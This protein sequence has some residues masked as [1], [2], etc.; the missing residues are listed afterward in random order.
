MTTLVIQ[1]VN[2]HVNKKIVLVCYFFLRLN[3]TF[4]EIKNHTQSTYMHL[5][6][7]TG[8]VNVL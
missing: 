8:T 7:R 4:L 2:I 3:I 6:H 5:V 1:I